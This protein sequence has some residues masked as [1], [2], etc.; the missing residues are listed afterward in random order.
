MKHGFP[1]KEIPYREPVQSAF[2]FSI[3]IS[4]DRMGDSPFVQAYVILDQYGFDPSALLMRPL[5]RSAFLND[6]AKV[7]I[8]LDFKTIFFDCLSQTA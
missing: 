1:E 8:D 6:G 4:L 2:Q 7:T 3:L 5:D